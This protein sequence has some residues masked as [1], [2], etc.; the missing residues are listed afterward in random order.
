ML[1]QFNPNGCGTLPINPE[2]DSRV[3]LTGSSTRPTT[4]SYQNGARIPLIAENKAN[5]QK[6][7]QSSFKDDTE[8]FL[9]I[10]TRSSSSAGPECVCLLGMA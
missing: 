4:Q 1:V 9:S 8:L 2:R 10:L 3:L 7:S 6:R 5:S